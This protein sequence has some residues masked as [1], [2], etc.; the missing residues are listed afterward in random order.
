M[1]VLST[2]PDPR[3]GG[4]QRRSLR[5]A[6]SL[7][8]RRVETVF[9]V[10]DGTDEFA[11]RAR[12]DDFEVHQCKLPRIRRISMVDENLRFLL[13][14]R[15]TASRIQSVIEEVGVD[16]VHVNTPINFAPAY[17]A[18]AADVAL[19]WHF[20]DTL[21]PT[22]VR[23]IAA[24]AAQH[25][26]DEIVVAS[27]AVAEYFFADSIATQTIYAPVDLEEFDPRT[28]GGSEVRRELDLAPET[29]V[30]GTVGN[31]NPVKGHEYLVESIPE[32]LADNGDVVVLIAGDTLDSRRDYATRLRKLVDRLGVEDSVQFLG[33]RED[34]PALLDALD[35]FVLPSVSEACPTVVLEAMAMETAIVAT[36]VGGVSEQIPDADHGWVV[37]PKNSDALASALTNAL[38]SA[39]ERRRRATN[40]RRRAEEIF[41]LDVCTERH[42]QT[43]RNAVPDN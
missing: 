28:T 32:V 26:A 21:T 5:V 43:Y 41:S 7:R 10:P 27:D 42:R 33:W 6:R 16:V 35:V 3:L 14:F 11:R 22:P 24:V 38:S 25:W 19:V 39:S 40:A 37:P 1:R 34:V 36:D 4:P 2:F 18:H 20:N 30:I 17:A 23:Q 15:K 9:L 12:A 13:T 29:P 31:L 8:D